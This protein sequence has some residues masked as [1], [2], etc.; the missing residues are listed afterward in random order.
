MQSILKTEAKLES[1]D[2][3]TYDYCTVLYVNYQ[4]A[5]KKILDWFHREMSTLANCYNYSLPT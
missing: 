4:K 2:V 5:S 1:F 3:V